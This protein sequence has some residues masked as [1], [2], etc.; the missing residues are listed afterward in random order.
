MQSLQTVMGHW[1]GQEGDWS[2]EEPSGENGEEPSMPRG[3]SEE[4]E[5]EEEFEEEEDEDYFDEGD[6]V[7]P[8]PSHAVCLSR[9]LSRALPFILGSIARP[10]NASALSR[11]AGRSFKRFHR[12]A[13]AF[14]PL[15]QIVGSIL[16][17][18][19]SERNLFLLLLP[20]AR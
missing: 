15:R 17:H 8:L 7:S 9:L 13:V 10:D 20:L 19:A 3:R 4:E 11:T 18:G 14:L 6:D 5:E 16:H 12:V 1:E 2:A